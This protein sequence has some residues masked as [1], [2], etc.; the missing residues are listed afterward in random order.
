[1]GNIIFFQ[2]DEVEE[3]EW[4][5]YYGYKDEF[6]WDCHEKQCAYSLS[7]QFNFTPNL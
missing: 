6:L 5:E 1:M 7:Q 2:Q 3:V 4:S